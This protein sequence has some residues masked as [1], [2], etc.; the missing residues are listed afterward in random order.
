MCFIWTYKIKH[1]HVY[2]KT[3]PI[4]KHAAYVSDTTSIIKIRSLQSHSNWIRINRIDLTVF[5]IE[6]KLS[7]VHM[8]AGQLNCNARGRTEFRSIDMIGARKWI[9]IQHKNR[10]QSAFWIDRPYWNAHLHPLCETIAV[11]HRFDTWIPLPGGGG[12]TNGIYMAIWTEC[13][14]VICGIWLL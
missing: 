11:G 2:I 13:V 1:E 12:E 4:R 9:T 3:N 7:I 14:N 5:C 8:P 6:T 10:Y